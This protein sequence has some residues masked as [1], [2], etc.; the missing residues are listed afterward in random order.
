MPMLLSGGRVEAGAM[1]KFHL[2]R[3]FYTDRYGVRAAGVSGYANGCLS[4][5]KQLNTLRTHPYISVHIRTDRNALK[6]QLELAAAAPG[7]L[8]ARRTP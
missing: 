7:P 5:Y 8:R 2:E 1:Q 4:M 6:W 3:K